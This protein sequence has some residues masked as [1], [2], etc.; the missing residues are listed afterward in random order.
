[1]DAQQ[2]EF[3]GNQAFF[4]ILGDLMILRTFVEPDFNRNDAWRLVASV[5]AALTRDFIIPSRPENVL[6]ANVVPLPNDNDE[7]KRLLSGLETCAHEFSHAVSTLK[8]Y[9]A[10]C[11]RLLQTPSGHPDGVQN[12]KH[13]RAR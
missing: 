8:K 12:P 6:P 9:F 11:P 10:P 13:H 3:L 2:A 5:T 4:S 1:M 7:I